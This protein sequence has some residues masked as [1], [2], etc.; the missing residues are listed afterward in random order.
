MKESATE[1]AD[2]QGYARGLRRAAA[3]ASTP[4]YRD[5]KAGNLAR[6]LTEMAEKAE[7]SR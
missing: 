4:D 2:R 6:L 1:V 7:A 5:A 3:I